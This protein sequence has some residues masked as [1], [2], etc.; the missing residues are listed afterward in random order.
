ML[1]KKNLKRIKL[2][3]IENVERKCVFHVIIIILAGCT[4]MQS[5][6]KAS[7]FS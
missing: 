3:S 6:Q 7:E 2:F 5:V 4:C 1:F